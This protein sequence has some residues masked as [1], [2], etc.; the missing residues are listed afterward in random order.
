MNNDGRDCQR[1]SRRVVP[2]GAVLTR[3]AAAIAISQAVA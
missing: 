3:G 1:I 2:S